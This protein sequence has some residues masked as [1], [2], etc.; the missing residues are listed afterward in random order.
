[1]L[2]WRGMQHSAAEASVTGG[3]H[4]VSVGVVTLLVWPRFST[5]DSFSSQ[6]FF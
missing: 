3:I 6:K 1:M 5:E 4:C 2:A